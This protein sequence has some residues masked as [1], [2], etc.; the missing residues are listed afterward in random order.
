MRQMSVEE[1]AERLATDGEEPP[2]LL[3]VREPWEFNICHIEGSR[4]LPMG[5][6]QQRMRHL[7]PDFETVVICHHGVRSR[8]VAYYLEQAGFTDIINLKRGLD[9]WARSVDVDMAT[10]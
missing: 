1:L 9:G 10:Y 3:D 7:D 5:E 6:I 4:L 8:R 2:L